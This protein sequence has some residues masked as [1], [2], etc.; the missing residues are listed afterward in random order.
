MSHILGDG[1]TKDITVLFN[2][3]SNVMRHFETKREAAER[4]RVVLMGR[5]IAQFLEQTSQVTDGDV[6]M[7]WEREVLPPNP[8][9]RYTSSTRTSDHII[10]NQGLPDD[11]VDERGSEKTTKST[12]A[13]ILD[14]IKS[15][16][17]HAANILRESLELTAGGVVFLDTAL[18][19]SDPGVESSYFDISIDAG[20]GDTEN[21]RRGD[22]TPADLTF[23]TST[24]ASQELK[25]ALKGAFGRGGT[26]MISN[27]QVSY[28]YKQLGSFLRG[29]T[30]P[31]Q[32]R[33]FNDQYRA[34]KVLAISTSD[35][36]CWGPSSKAIDQK[37]LQSLMDV[38]PK[39]NVWYIDDEGCFSSLEQV[40]QL[41][42]RDHVSQPGRRRSL[43]LVD[44]TRQRAEANLLARVFEGA[45]QIIFLPLWDVGGSKT[46]R[47]FLLSVITVLYIRLIQCL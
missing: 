8:P 9:E 42:E 2:S 18:G 23:N 27:T 36:A 28:P 11:D 45:R 22:D 32:V 30:S 7:A 38:Y 17:D 4:R 16:L 39:G 5:G 24:S 41:H 15:T 46:P 29:G 14:R 12:S 44:T 25:G 34:A 20:G 26:P 21:K 37:T 3:A 43:Q 10:H 1:F 47:S 6:N 31:T 35:V 33:G 40:A 13:K 19:Y